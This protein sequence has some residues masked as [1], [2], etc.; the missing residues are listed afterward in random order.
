MANNG[1]ALAVAA[2]A[3]YLCNLLLLPLLAFLLL[4]ML[5]YRYSRS[6][7]ELATMH[8][9]QTVGASV[10]A[11][12]LLLPIPLLTLAISGTDS[13]MGWTVSILYFVVC[14]AALVLAGALGLA[15]AMAGKPY[16][17]PLI[18]GA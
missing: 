17:Y 4:L 5:H 12:V 11:G 9:R 7:N 8:L 15:R 16:R 18:G 3:L 6:G 14:H 2:E 1:K 10:W 13:P